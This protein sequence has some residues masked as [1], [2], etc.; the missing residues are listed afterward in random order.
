MG[1]LGAAGAGFGC[2][3][4]AAGYCLGCGAAVWVWA[5]GDG[6]GEDGEAPEA[7]LLAAC[8]RSSLRILDDS[9]LAFGAA[10]G[11]TGFVSVFGGSA[12]G[13]AEVGGE[14]FGLG[15]RAAVGFA[16][17]SGIG[18]LVGEAFGAVTVD[19]PVLGA[20]LVDFALVVV[21]FAPSGISTSTGS[22]MTFFGLP[23]F[24]ATSVGI[25]RSE[26][27]ALKSCNDVVRKG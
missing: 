3:D 12:L 24:L 9:G 4:R 6:W 15:F 25:L 20:A 10:F 2:E 22:V 14:V 27:V 13:D 1:I 8:W 5:V 18:L 21:F 26:L 19:L 23:L 17:A 7:L 11:A 16:V